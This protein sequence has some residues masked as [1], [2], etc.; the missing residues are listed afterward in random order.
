M[1]RLTMFFFINLLVFSDT[2]SEPSDLTVRKL[3]ILDLECYGF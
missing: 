2:L 3:R 1:E